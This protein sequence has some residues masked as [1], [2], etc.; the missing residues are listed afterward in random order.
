VINRR[1]F[2][3]RGRSPNDPRA[4]ERAFGARH[5]HLGPTGFCAGHY[6][7][8]IKVTIPTAVWKMRLLLRGIVRRIEVAKRLLSMPYL[9]ARRRACG[10]YR[11]IRHIT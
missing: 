2:A 1:Q 7:A 3:T 11:Y 8:R 6:R 4:K 9:R 5:P 10:T